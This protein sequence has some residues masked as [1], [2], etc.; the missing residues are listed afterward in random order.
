MTPRSA[1][2]RRDQ[3]P[4]RPVDGGDHER[5]HSL[6]HRRLRCGGA[7]DVKQPDGEL[8]RAA[9]KRSKYEGVVLFSSYRGDVQAEDGHEHE[10]RH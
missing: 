8:N 10:L 4:E 1:N 2:R 7:C 5:W 3:L 9:A 6:F